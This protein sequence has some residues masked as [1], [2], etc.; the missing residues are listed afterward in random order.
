M[1]TISARADPSQP[2]EENKAFPQ[3]SFCFDDVQSFHNKWAVANP[4]PLVPPPRLHSE[5]PTAWG[6]H[7]NQL[8]RCL[9]YTELD[10]KLLT[11][12]F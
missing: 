10:Y 7:E 3:K 11:S 9:H 8:Q 6:M 4:V 5:W 12:F 2:Q 1:Q